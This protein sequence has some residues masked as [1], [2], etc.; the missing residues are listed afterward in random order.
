MQ[1]TINQSEIEAA[2]RAHLQSRLNIKA[3]AKMT[4]ELAATRGV[5]GFTAT[6]ELAQE[7][8]FPNSSSESV[9]PL[10]AAQAT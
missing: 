2:I 10:A 8:L 5:D 1:I 3:S 7:D 6:V 4:V 9:H